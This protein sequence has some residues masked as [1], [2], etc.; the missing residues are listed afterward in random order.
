MIRVKCQV[1]Q[2]IRVILCLKLNGFLEGVK[3]YIRKVINESNKRFAHS[4][5]IPAN[6]VRE[7]NLKGESV[8][9]KVNGNIISITKI[10]D[11]SD[12]MPKKITT[13]KPGDENSRGS[14]DGL[15]I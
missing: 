12:D 15:I 5:N 7:L 11:E 9:I 2:V 3:H 10:T 14:S 1:N 6:V 13:S 4:I 8:R